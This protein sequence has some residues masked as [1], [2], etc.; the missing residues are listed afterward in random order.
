MSAS[1]SDTRLNDVEG[2]RLDVEKK[3]SANAAPA[4]HTSEELKLEGDEHPQ[5]MPASRKWLAIVVI[6]SA[7]F[8]C[9]CASSIVREVAATLF[10]PFQNNLLFGC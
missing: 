3:G 1:D 6:S 7:S 9:T 10:T 5:N 4:A 8:C 2:P